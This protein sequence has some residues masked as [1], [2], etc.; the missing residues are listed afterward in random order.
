[1][2]KTFVRNYKDDTNALPLHDADEIVA[3]LKQGDWIELWVIDPNKSENNA[4]YTLV[5][6]V[7][8]TEFERIGKPVVG[9]EELI[10]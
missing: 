10:K 2:K 1:M 8:D 9:T 3:N 4:I 7:S 5:E 6:V